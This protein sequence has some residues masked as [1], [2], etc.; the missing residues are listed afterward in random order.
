MSQPL[1]VD[2]EGIIA[3]RASSPSHVRLG[4]AG[5]KWNPARKMEQGIWYTQ[6]WNGLWILRGG[7]S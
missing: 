6:W 1:A 5:S 3:I 2:V 7:Q 4:E